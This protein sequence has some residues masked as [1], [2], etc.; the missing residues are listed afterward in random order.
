MS[1]W[2]SIKRKARKEHSCIYCRK[3]IAKGEE[4]S[5][6]TG[7]FEG[8]FNDYCLCLR[9]AWLID[10]FE[11][12]NEYLADIWET[13]F[14]NDLIPCPSCGSNNLREYDMIENKQEMECE[15]DKCNE[16]WVA[17]LSIEGL[18][19]IIQATN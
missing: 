18:K 10:T 4:Y 14:N 16:K 6:E 7:T 8:D 2:N 12:D 5:R 3:T 11:T 9:C 19:E 1:F 13:L 17:D 15:C